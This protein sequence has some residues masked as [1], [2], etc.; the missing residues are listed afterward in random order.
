MC[1][2]QIHLQNTETGS[3][4]AIDHSTSTGRIFRQKAEL[5]LLLSTKWTACLRLRTHDRLLFGMLGRCLPTSVDRHCQTITVLAMLRITEI[6]AEM[7]EMMMPIKTPP[8][9]EALRDLRV[10]GSVLL[11][12]TYLKPWAIEIPDEAE[13]RHLTGV[14]PQIR[15]FPFH[16]VRDGHFH[17][18]HEGL[19]AVDVH[20]DEV[21]ICPSGQSHTMSLGRADRTVPFRDILNGAAPHVPSASN[22]STSLLCGLF[23]L[24]SAPLNPILSALP[25]ILKIST[26]DGHENPIL[27][28]AAEMLGLEVGRGQAS[29]FSAQRLLEIFFAEAI[30]AYRKQQGKGRPGWFQA[31]GDR[32][33]GQAISLMHDAPGNAWSL[34]ELASSI[35]MS[36]SRFAARFREVMGMSVM[37]YLTRWR[38]NVA[39]RHL[40]DTNLGLAEIAEMVGYQDVAAFSRA[41]KSNLGQSPALWR[42]SATPETALSE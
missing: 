4:V 3:A 20:K 14:G 11:F 39:C 17:L 37:T 6:I 16:F 26:S 12:E 5:A 25:P 34:A 31:L 35:S 40:R 32:R 33:I 18:K 24:Q 22:A 8:F 36:K 1:W 10:S 15:V 30:L 38:M 7:T 42:K 23:F 29:S 9:D 27:S 21:A 2:V 13:L 28:R 41:F 19:E